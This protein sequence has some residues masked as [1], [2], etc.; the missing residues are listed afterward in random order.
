M[1]VFICLII[2][3]MDSLP[4]YDNLPWK[5]IL[6]ALQ[7]TLSPE[8][9]LQLREWLAISGD[10]Q[11]KYD[12]L[13]GL[14]KDGLADYLFYREADEGKAWEALQRRMNDKGVITPSFP[15]SRMAWMAAAAVILLAVGAGWWYR[16][17]KSGSVPYET[18]FNEQKKI[19][20]PDGSTVV[21]DPQ[22]RIR[23]APGFNKAGRTVILTSGEAHFDVFHQEQLPFI[24]DM[25]AVSVKDIGTN[26]TVQKTKDSIKV[27]VTGGKV[28]FIN[29]E[30]GESRDLAAGSSLIY[31][32]P[33]RRFGEIQAADAAGGNADSLRFDN[34]PLSEVI[35]V[36]Q[37]VSGKKISLNDSALG[38]KRLT[39]HLD[40]ESFD[41]ALKTICASLDLESSEKDGVYILSGRTTAPHN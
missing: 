22:T 28:A 39:V 30:S 5:L 33:E 11:Q 9:D 37:K 10:N 14:W 6:S 15:M 32:V 2:E 18:T 36:L 31:Y 24:V 13:R 19:S 26:F 41:N 25:D 38:Q 23:V 8:E 1:V 12:Q 27:T 7:G 4:T 3:T 20:L 16:S 17:G 34:S 35:A 29:K 21:L 40:G